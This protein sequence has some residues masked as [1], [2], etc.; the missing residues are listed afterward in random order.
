MPPKL[1]AKPKPTATPTA[2][3]MASSAAWR[4]RSAMARPP[5]TAERAM[6]SARNRSIRPD[7]ESS[8]KKMLTPK[9]SKMAM[10]AR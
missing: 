4:R 8:A 7:F 9:P 10:V 2:V 5:T 6:G 3:V 1:P